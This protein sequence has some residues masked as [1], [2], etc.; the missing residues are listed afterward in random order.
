MKCESFECLSPLF[1]FIFDQQQPS[2]ALGR[3]AR[4]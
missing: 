1:M 4:K 3:G 2:Q